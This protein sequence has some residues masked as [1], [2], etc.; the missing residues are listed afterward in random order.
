MC[1]IL[2]FIPNY[3]PIVHCSQYRMAEDERQNGPLPGHKKV[4]CWLSDVQTV[5]YSYSQLSYP[6]PPAALRKDQ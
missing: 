5:Y 3:S 1:L 6:T 4:C 2:P